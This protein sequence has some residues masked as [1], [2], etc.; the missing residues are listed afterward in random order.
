M[1]KILTVEIFE[2]DYKWSNY[3]LLFIID[4][5][6]NKRENMLRE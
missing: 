4:Q 6:P 2:S 1:F 5:Q 3:C